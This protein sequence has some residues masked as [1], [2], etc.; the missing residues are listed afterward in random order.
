MK[1]FFFT[2]IIAFSAVVC[3]CSD[4]VAVTPA[5]KDYFTLWNSCEAVTALQDY[6]KDITDPSSKNFI[7]EEDRIATFDMDGTFIG[8]LYPT[9]FEYNLLEYRVLD[10]ETYKDIAPDDV[11]ETAQ[12]IR[13]FVRKG[14]KLPSH[15]DLKHAQ[16]AAKAYAGMTLAQ[17]RDYV[18][19]YAAKQ[20]NGFSGMTY[21]Q[22]FYKPMLQVFDYLK[23]NGF[24]YYVVSGSDRFICRALVDDIGIEPNR[25]IGMDVKL[26]S[27]SQGSE[28]GVD[29]TMGKEEDLVR[30]DELIIK[31]L[32]TNKVLQIT[33]E[34]G[35]VPVLSFGN[36]SGDCAMHNY[37]LSNPTYKSAAFMLIADD[38]LRDHADRDKALSL[39]TQWHENGYHVISMRDDFKTIY[40][41]G[42]EKTDFTFPVDTRAL[43]EWQAGKTVTDEEIEAF[44]GIDKC[45]AAEPIPDNVWNR[46]QGKTYKDNPYIGRSDL[47]HIRALHWDYDQKIH[48]GEM[49]CNVM[50][51]DR[52]ARILRQ[53]YDAKYPIQRMLLPDVYDA[54]DETQMRDNNSSCFCYRSIA[55]STKLSKHARGLAVDINT[56][57]NPY[58]K[59]R[60][61]G[62]RFIQPAT[63]E[64]YCDRTKSFPY[65]ID[66]SD[67]CF[68][69]FT[70]AGFEW[71]GD[72]TSCKDFQHFELIEE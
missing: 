41:E 68:R 44:G 39:G 40:G 6:M 59:D 25:V 28:A 64:E 57:Y 52:V 42:V 72:W 8:E 56:L 38:D 31:N 26:R 54:D 50:I 17:F 7:K 16:A 18:K 36:S 14:Q 55:G 48:V 10:D 51:A 49:I 33:Q 21:G 1:K 70:E 30:T 60:A 46:M 2:L 32:K 65:K 61:D 66:H 53:L 24:T 67:L 47:R 12:E 35:K 11:K 63:A 4:D 13:D 37:C 34:I 27:T 23:A 20:A 69:L 45:F 3:S 29:Y 22:S 71:G 43:T 62:T 15:F 58:Y 19:A 9:Y 5:N